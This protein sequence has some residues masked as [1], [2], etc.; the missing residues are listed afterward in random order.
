MAGFEEMSNQLKDHIDAPILKATVG[1]NLLGVKTLFS[2]CGFDYK[3]PTVAKNHMLNKPYFF[4]SVGNKN[5]GDLTPFGRTIL[6][7]IMLESGWQFKKVSEGVIDFY[8]YDQEWDSYH[9]FGKP[10]SVHRFESPC[11]AIDRLCAAINNWRSDFCSSVI[12]RDGNSEYLKSHKYWQYK[13]CEDWAV[14]P[15]I[16]DSL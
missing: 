15:D 11:L 10:Q 14:T 9:P 4:I 8:H 3:N 1:L 12:V 6:F 13:P 2:C 5:M 16:F 7:D